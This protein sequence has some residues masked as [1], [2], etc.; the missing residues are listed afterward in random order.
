MLQISRGAVIAMHGC[1]LIGE[2]AG[3]PVPA[4]EIASVFG[5]SAAHV[6]KVMQRLC[7]AGVVRSARGPDGGFLLA[8]PPERITLLKAVSAVDG[9]I[10]PAKCLLG[11]HS[12]LR[13]RC[14]IGDFAS[15]FEAEFKKV[16]S[17]TLAEAAAYSHGKKPA[18]RA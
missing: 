13:R 3:R 14:M 1:V 4:G 12:C 2:A 17:R 8:A 10:A 11:R 6:S 16:L 9:K 18:P 15:R 7:R 5:V